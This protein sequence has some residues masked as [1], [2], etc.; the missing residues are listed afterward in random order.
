VY[1]KN[2][3]VY[4]SST[5]EF[6]QGEIVNFVQTD[7]S[8]VYG[9]MQWFP[10]FLCLPLMLVICLYLIFAT[11]G[12]SFFAC[13]GVF[14]VGGL[15]TGVLAKLIFKYHKKYMAKQ[16]KRLNI[17]T[18]CL[19]NIKMVKLYA[20][21]DIFLRNIDDRRAEELSV[22]KTKLWYNISMIMVFYFMPA[23][24]QS[25]AFTVFIGMGHTLDLSSAFFLIS[26]FS[27]IQ[28]PLRIIPMFVGYLTQFLVSLKRIQRFLLLEEINP[29]IVSRDQA[30]AHTALEDAQVAACLRGGSNFIWGLKK[31]K[32]GEGDESIDKDDHKAVLEARKGAKKG[33]KNGSA[34]RDKE[35]KNHGSE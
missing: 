23:A 16:D 20:W 7:C 24:L 6:S 1:E 3:R 21:I 2:L 31:K 18:E 28:L 33:K 35:G 10:F 5:S 17:T 19:N 8:T 29:T 14:V 26:V 4:P 32:E 30:E 34:K 11:L 12:V 22:Y 25:T 15:V 9:V 13:V 27:I